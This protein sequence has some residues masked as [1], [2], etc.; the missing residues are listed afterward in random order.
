MAEHHLPASPDTVHWGWF[1]AGLAPVMTV[2]PGERV[3]IESVSGGP[4]NLPP[5]GHVVPPEL[6]EIHARAE[7]RRP[8]H[9]LT[10]PVAV[11]GARPGDVLEVR[12]LEV[13][14]WTDWG[15]T[16]VGALGGALPGEFDAAQIHSTL[17]PERGTARLPWGTELKLSPFF[18]VMGVAPP[19]R[20]GEIPTI[21][22]RAH[23]GNLDN[24]E[25]GAGA[26]LYLP[27]WTEGALFS[28][29]DGHGIQ[30]DGEVC[31]TAIETA[32]RGTFEFHLHKGKGWDYPRAE[33][34]TH[35]I[36]MGLHEDLDTAA[37][38][39]LRR[40]IDWLAAISDL[41]RTDAYMLM[42][43]AGDIRI[44]QVVN[45]EKGSHAMLPK[46]VLETLPGLRAPL[47]A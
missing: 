32:L 45:G 5:E 2:E 13:A 30:G 29:G 41:S 33:T 47:S 34:P 7:R 19:A 22:P 36:T 3:T 9:I 44:T 10:G 21:Q 12:I 40:M 37:R 23:G 15:Y 27:V 46:S 35:L 20:W 25:L 26:T 42:S 11:R 38:D 1:S 18:G 31:L 6:L 43:L 14:P 8:G 24:K 16:S 4:A 28:C 17:D 39:A